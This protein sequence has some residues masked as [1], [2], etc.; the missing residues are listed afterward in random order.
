MSKPLQPRATTGKGYRFGR[1]LLVK[2]LG[3]GGMAQVW[4][5]RKQIHAGE[6]VC[7]IKMPAD[8]LGLDDANHEAL[9]NEIRISSQFSHSNIVQVFDSGVHRGVLYMEL[10]RI[11]GIDLD[12]LLDVMRQRQAP[13]SVGMAVYVWRCAGAG[14]EDI[15][16]LTSGNQ[17]VWFTGYGTGELH[18]NT[19]PALVLSTAQWSIG[20]PPVDIDG[21][22]RPNR[23]GTADV[24]GADVP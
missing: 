2:P 13:M 4:L 14:N 16:E 1:Y 6:K 3:Q 19:P 21:E 24:A 8:L 12:Q 23:D 17:D 18:L 7:A 11:D 9:L 10:E 15:G 22:P 20:D 5:A